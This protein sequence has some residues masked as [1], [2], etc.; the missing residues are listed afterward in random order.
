VAPD[1]ETGPGG[2]T[3]RG[4]ATSR[5]GARDGMARGASGNAEH[6]DTRD[7]RAQYCARL[8]GAVSRAG[9]R[10]ATL[11]P[12]SVQRRLGRH[13]HRCRC[14]AGAVAPERRARAPHHG[15]WGL[16]SVRSADLVLAIAF[17]ITSAE[18]SPLQLFPGPGSEAMQHAPWSFVPTV[19]VPIWLIQHAVVAVQLRRVKPG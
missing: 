17:G 15:N 5:G 9:G 11:R 3:L 1:F 2:R 7:R 19:L 16:E 8:C 18:G 14:G 4:R 13:H 10:G 6:T 12:V